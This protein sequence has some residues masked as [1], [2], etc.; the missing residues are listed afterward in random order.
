MNPADELR[1]AARRLRSG[2]LIA[3]ADLDPLLAR[4]LEFHAAMDER[5]HALVDG[6]PDMGE[7]TWDGEPHP[8]LA[9]A[10]QIN[11]NTSSKE[12]S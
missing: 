6:T 10:R 8:A 9:I 7:A 12:G 2:T 1:P 5:L 4:W 11:A 3:R